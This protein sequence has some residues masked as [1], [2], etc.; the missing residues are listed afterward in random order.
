MHSLFLQAFC[1]TP[2]P[3]PWRY[4]SFA[5]T[6][7][8]PNALDYAGALLSQGYGLDILDQVEDEKLIKLGIKPG[9][10]IHLKLHSTQWWNGLSREMKKAHDEQAQ[11]SEKHICYEHICDDSTLCNW[12]GPPIETG[13]LLR[14]DTQTKWHD[15]VSA[16][17]FLVPPG[18][19]APLH[20]EH[21]EQYKPQANEQY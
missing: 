19:T 12:T 20:K 15:P 13:E 7:G 2:S 3:Q 17:W 21:Y 10:I 14:L 16:T 6:K 1:L 4:L 8:I 5:Q 11:P 9:D 18:F